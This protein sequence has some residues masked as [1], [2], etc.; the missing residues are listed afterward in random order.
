MNKLFTLLVL[1]L[2]LVIFSQDLNVANIP[3]NIK[4]NANA[5][6]R[7]NREEYIFKSVDNL[8]IKNS[9]ATTIMN[10]SGSDFAYVVIHYNPTTRVSDIKVELLD[11]D[12][13]SIKSFGK[14]DFTD[15]SNGSNSP[16]YVDDRV[17]YLKP[18]S[19][20]YPYTV[21][22][23]Y[24]I[25]TSN[26]VYI[27]RFAPYNSFD[28]ALQKSEM[29]LT[30]NSG[31]KI[32]TKISETPL[33]KLKISENGNTSTYAY[34][35]VPAL[36]AEELAPTIDYLVPRIEFSPEK[37]T[38]EGKQGDLSDWNSF[39]KW[40]YNQL[41]NPVSK[42]TPEISAE[43]SGLNLQ[44]STADKVK[45]IYQYMQGKTR[46][47]LISMGIGGWQPMPASEVSKKGYG[48]CKALTNYMRTLLVAAGI[49]SYYA[50]IYSD[51]SVRNFDRD[52]PKLSGNHVVLMVPTED[53]E[54]WLENTSQKIAFNHL[55]YSSYNRNVL[56]VNENGIK[57]IDTPVYRP[58]QS[59]EKL[60]AKI[61]LK[62][63]GGFDSEAKMEFTGGQY[64]QNLRLFSLKNDEVQEA[65]KNRHYHLKFSS[66]NIKNL[67]NDKDHGKITYD[68][69]M[70]VNGF[71][72]KIG[73]D[74]FFQAMPFYQTAMYSGTDERKLPLEI[75]FP[76][77]NDYEIEF[78]IPAGYRLSEVPKSSDFSSEFGSYS[79]SFDLKDN[80]LMVRRIL[81]IKKG[82]YPKE[83]YKEYFAFRKKT[84]GNDNVKVLITKL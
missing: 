74:L 30:N 16:L 75:S 73:N 5:V 79:I 1:L 59:K 71:S 58:E 81:T 67:N 36:K 63:D 66:L 10:E 35:N 80:K 83:K 56:G 42:I 78:E 43:I 20:K 37:F 60:T 84:A 48:D 12:G 4:E 28:V 34:E 40:Y 13:K 24:E 41:I 76:F 3:E 47:V 51:E 69:N 31:I 46:Y 72:K 39:G 55:S 9:R 32:R 25:S 21:K 38:L 64:D 2:P 70:E 27:S 18:I 11:S 44:G 33:A 65:M 61:I 6:I 54:I 50:V 53:G 17:L 68:L 29:T 19:T 57:I 62:E 49:P 7:E 14:R 45:T 22:Y 8:T 52:F 77:Q 82:N 15:I 26:T 23:S